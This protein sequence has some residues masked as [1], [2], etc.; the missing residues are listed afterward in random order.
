MIILRPAN[1]TD[2]EALCDLYFEFHEFHAR[3]LPFFLRSLGEPSAEEREELKR[4]LMEIIQGSGSAILVAEDS[5]HVIGFA[6]IYLRQPDQSIR[7]V[8]PITYAHLQSFM[9]TDSFRCKGI[10]RQLLQAVE[11]WSLERGAVELRLDTWDFS[12]GPLDFYQKSGYRTYR[13][14]LVKNLPPY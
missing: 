9:V 14:S 5:R 3:Y 2:L 13:R 4:R 1:E 7:G 8:T 11:A 6:E 10:G 12:A